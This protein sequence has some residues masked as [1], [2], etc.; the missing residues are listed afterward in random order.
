MADGCEAVADRIARARSS[1]E[2]RRQLDRLL[3]SNELAARQL[4]LTSD[5]ISR[6][7]P[8]PVS[9][10]RVRSGTR[11]QSEPPRIRLDAI[12]RYSC[13]RPRSDCPAPIAKHQAGRPAGGVGATIHPLHVAPTSRPA[14]VF[15]RLSAISQTDTADDSSL[16]SAKVRPPREGCGLAARAQAFSADDGRSPAQTARD[17]VPHRRQASDPL[18]V[19]SPPA[20]TRVHPPRAY[21][22]TGPATARSPSFNSWPMAARTAKSAAA[23]TS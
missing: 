21:G 10:R 6:K 9:R 19:D 8:L 17:A 20:V 7:S 18:D 2:E 16:R 14:Q 5:P 4:H 23:S 12:P 13:P 15:Y 1:L 3:E 22:R 11:T